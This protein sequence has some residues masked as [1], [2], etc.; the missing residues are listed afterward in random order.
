[1]YA[2]L[3]LGVGVWLP[4]ST[5]PMF[6][7][8]VTKAG[9]IKKWGKILSSRERQADGIAWRYVFHSQGVECSKCGGYSEGTSGGGR[10]AGRVCWF[11][12]MDWVL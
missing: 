6:L 8:C 3:S 7:G 10:Q 4:Q 12:G 5:V 11:Q 2:C 9:K 1:M